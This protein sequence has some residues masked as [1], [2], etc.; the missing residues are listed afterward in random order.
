MINPP[1]AEFS[2]GTAFWATASCSS[3]TAPFE[4]IR[5]IPDLYGWA[6]GIKEWYMEESLLIEF[7][8]KRCPVNI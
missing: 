6:V 4:Y 5:Y 1:S 3:D 2:P 8:N 7:R